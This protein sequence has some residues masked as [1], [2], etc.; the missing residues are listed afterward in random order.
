MP[1]SATVATQAKAVQTE[2]KWKEKKEEGVLGLGDL[3]WKRDQGLLLK[4]G[5]RRGGKAGDDIGEW[6]SVAEVKWRS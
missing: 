3:L 6:H 1:G 2:K 4:A 5:R